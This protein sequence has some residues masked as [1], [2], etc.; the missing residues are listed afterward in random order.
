[1]MMP[2]QYPTFNPYMM[3]QQYQGF[4]PYM[5]SPQS[6]N[7]YMMSPQ[8]FNPF[9]M[10]P[11]SPMMMMMPPQQAATTT[12]TTTKGTLKMKAIGNNVKNLKE[13]FDV[14]KEELRVQKTVVED[15]VR[16]VL[17]NAVKTAP[18]NNK[19][20]DLWRALKDLH[21]HKEPR[22]VHVKEDHQK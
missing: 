2:S 4:N 8:G 18:T 1:M 16:D 5:M 20:L 10:S 12:T 21:N 9:M 13:E 14:L 17:L 3:Q 15:T 22:P 11:Q 6:F 7:P 19:E